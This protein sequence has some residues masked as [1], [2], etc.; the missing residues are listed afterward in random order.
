ML[1]LLSADYAANDA[2][3]D[4]VQVETLAGLGKER[5]HVLAIRWRPVDR[6]HPG[7]KS[8]PMVPTGSDI[9]TRPVPDGN[10]GPRSSA[11]S[12]LCWS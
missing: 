2:C 7:L 1:L 4:E 5:L 11:A 3:Y 9:A 10:V 8:L 6:G 12:G